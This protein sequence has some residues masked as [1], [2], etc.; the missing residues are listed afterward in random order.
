MPDPPHPEPL[1]D[2]GID[3]RGRRHSARHDGK[4]C[5]EEIG[6]LEPDLENLLHRQEET[7]KRARHHRHRDA[8]SH[9]HPV[10]EHDAR[11]GHDIGA[12]DR[13]N[14]FR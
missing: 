3:Q 7:V 11:T 9:R 8:V 4:A 1:D 12:A 6:P 13:G 10:S 2:P 14:V 5:G